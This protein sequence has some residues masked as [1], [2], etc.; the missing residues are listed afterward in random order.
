[1]A[2]LA[3][4]TKAIEKGSIIQPLRSLH[5]KPKGSRQFFNG[6][7]DTNSIAQLKKGYN[8]ISCVFFN[9]TRVFDA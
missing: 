7:Y 3:A 6:D 2:D 8:N 4:I 1:M 9:E 5:S